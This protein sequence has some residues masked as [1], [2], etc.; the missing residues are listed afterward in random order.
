MS[1]VE[2]AEWEI[3]FLRK[4]LEMR[5][6]QIEAMHQIGLALYTQKDMDSMIR[7]TLL[8][9]L[10][11]VESDAGSILLYD[12]D[13]KR[14]VFRYVLGNPE[15][16]GQDIDPEEDI[17]GRASTVFRTGQSLLT[18]NTQQEG[19]N[20]RFDDKT[21]FRTRSILTVPLKN[22]GGETIGVLQALNKRNGDF[23]EDD[24]ELLEIVGGLA[25]TTLANFR[26]AEEAQLA[27]IARAVGDLGH[28]I[29][30]ALTPIET[31]IDTTVDAFLTPLFEEIDAL[32]PDHVYSVEEYQAKVLRALDPLRDWCPEMLTALKD[33]CGDIKEMVSEIADYIK[34]AQSTHMEAGN[35]AAVI[36]ER[37]R[38]LKV[39]AR[40]RKV[41]IDLSGLETVPDFPFDSRLV[42]RAVYNLVN[43]GLNAIYDAV[44]KGIMEYRHE[45]YKIWVSLDY[46]PQG[47]FPE[48]CYCSVIVRDDGPGIPDRVLKSLFTAQA[49]STTPGGTGIGTRFVNS[50]AEA[51]KGRVGVESE[52]GHGA[53]FWLKLP[54][55]QEETLP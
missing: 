40:D 10:P 19:Y 5:D 37:L 25:A 1:D 43:N 13:R 11:T 44:K 28:D 32:S 38:R 21:G 15:L 17:N 31:T 4:R 46:Q 27:A 23:D 35:I 30:N 49:I 14:L 47:V 22:I 6:R 9:A 53:L 29:K 33:G 7:E 45:G 51:H 3:E 39:V 16:V 26:M 48:G 20:P 41:R 36:Q 8:F 34:G 2:S 52:E 12:R 55:D 24:L 50:V 18:T 54:L 42:G